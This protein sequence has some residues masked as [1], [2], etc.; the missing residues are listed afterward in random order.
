MYTFLI[1]SYFGTSVDLGGL[2]QAIINVFASEP[3]T[4]VLSI[5][6]HT[7]LIQVCSVTRLK[8]KLNFALN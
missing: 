8:L 7:A 4:I 2:I 6:V 5:S 1:F 3:L